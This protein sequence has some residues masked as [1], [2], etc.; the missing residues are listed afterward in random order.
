[1]PISASQ[2]KWPV[3][4]DTIRPNSA[5][6]KIVAV[7]VWMRPVGVGHM[8]SVSS[9]ALGQLLGLVELADA[10]DDFACQAHLHRH[11]RRERPRLDVLCPEAV[12]D[13]AAR[14]VLEARD[15]VRVRH[16]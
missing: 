10:L 6:R 15:R 12:A 4:S 3:T 14:L 7:R 16:D 1:M 5:G 2:S 11:A 8:W 9:S 13:E